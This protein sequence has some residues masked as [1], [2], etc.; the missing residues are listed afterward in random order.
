M[1]ARLMAATGRPSLPDSLS[2]ATSEVMLAH[3]CRRGKSR[4]S[5]GQ[6]GKEHPRQESGRSPWGNSPSITRG[7]ESHF[8]TACARRRP[9]RHLPGHTA[10]TLQR[11]EQ[12]RAAVSSWQGQVPLRAVP[13]VLL[14]ACRAGWRRWRGRGRG[15]A[16]AATAQA[17]P[18]CQ[19]AEGPCQHS[20]ACWQELCT[21]MLCSHLAPPCWRPSSS[22]WT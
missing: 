16:K 8:Q 14:C 15:K 11:R 19:G 9:G 7:H 10:H 22:S 1:T 5:L 18:P 20:S 12:M 2:L 21:G 4:I 17:G 13:R 6:K 3:D